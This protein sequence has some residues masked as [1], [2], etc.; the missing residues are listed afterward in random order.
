MG[1]DAWSWVGLLVA[2]LALVALDLAAFSRGHRTPSFRWSVLVTLVVTAVGAGFTLF[3]WMHLGSRPAGEYLTGYLIERSLS[4]DNVFVFALVLG[5]FGVPATAR[6]RVLLWGVVGALVLRGAF[7][8]AGA[9]MLDA[10]HWTIY[11][12][13]AL[14]VVTGIRTALHDG[15]EVHPER[16]PILRL[17][18]RAVPS[19]A[20]YHGARFLVREGDRR[21]A[22]PLLAVLAVVATSDVVFAID[23][24]PAIFAVTRDTYLVVAA[25]AFSVLGLPA[26]YF[27]LAGMMD[28]FRLLPYGL[29]MVLVFVGVKMAASDLVEIPVLASLAV[30]VAVLGGAVLLSLWLPGRPSR[31]ASRPSTAL[32]TVEDQPSLP[33]AS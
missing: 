10:F 13:G 21:L 18:R 4:V 26:L 9:A 5:A 29:A 33:S 3:V 28:R 19:T 1:I 7:I 17:L 32:G 27:V 22:T 6:H 24:I 25:N 20:A 30:V 8:V 11:V 14:L 31:T 23:S 2:T 15:T 12:F 16:N